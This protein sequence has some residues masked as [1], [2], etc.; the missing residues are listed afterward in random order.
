[1]RKK[2]FGTRLLNALILSTTSVLLVTVGWVAIELLLTVPTIWKVWVGTV[3][4]VF[5]YAL[6]GQ[7][8]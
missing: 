8:P 5:F 2:S 4:L 7:E 1:M 3:L 6:E